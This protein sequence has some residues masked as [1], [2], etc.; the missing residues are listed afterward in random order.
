M[1]DGR[2]ERRQAGKP[3]LHKRTS[4]SRKDAKALR[5][6]RWEGQIL[7]SVSR[8]KQLQIHAKTRRREGNK[9]NKLQLPT[10][11]TK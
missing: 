2:F 1:F 9:D 5:T 11:M 4:V 7:A 6:A 10:A 8:M 3:V